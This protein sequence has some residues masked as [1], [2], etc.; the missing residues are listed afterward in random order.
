MLEAIQDQT[1][2][3]KTFPAEAESPDDWLRGTVLPNREEQF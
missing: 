3:K 1:V 2:T